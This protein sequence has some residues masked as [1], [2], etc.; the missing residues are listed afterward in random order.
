MFKCNLSIVI[1]TICLNGCI[2]QSKSDIEKAKELVKE[3]EAYINTEEAIIKRQGLNIE[4]QLT[5]ELKNKIESKGS[6]ELKNSAEWVIKLC[7]DLIKV[8]DNSIAI[9]V[10][11]QG[12]DH[13]GDMKDKMN[14]KNVNQIFI[15]EG[16]AKLIKSEIQKSI[17]SHMAIV[18][19]HDLKIERSD[20]ALQLDLFMEENGESWEEYT[21]KD[22]PPGPLLP[23]IKKYR[24]DA[25]LTKLQVLESLT[26]LKEK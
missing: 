17:E 12:K 2:G 19:N 23:I 7:A 26:K 18:K 15:E 3:A 20:L 24:N 21:F 5:S 13:N 22:M 14:P 1:F 8:L 11:K 4:Y 16:R 9:L 6:V 10:D 25:V